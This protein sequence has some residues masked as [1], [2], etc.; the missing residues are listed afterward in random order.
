RS[1]NRSGHLPDDA[2]R[3]TGFRVALGEMPKTRPTP[4][5]VPLHQKDVKQA[6][7]PK[8]GPDPKKPYFVNYTAEGKAPTMAKDSWGPVFSNH[9]HFGAVCVCPNGDVLMAWYSTVTEPGREMVQAA[10]RLRAGSDKWEPASLFFSIPDVN[11]HAPVLMSD[12]KRLY[13]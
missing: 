10:S 1:A 8:D 12:G 11:C 5:S 9:T 3:A 4:V 13:H 6:A 2:D 7:A